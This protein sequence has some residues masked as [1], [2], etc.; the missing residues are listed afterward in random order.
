M[1]KRID[2]SI[3]VCTYNRASLL[4]RALQ[5][6]AVQQC[7]EGLEYEV[8]VVDDGSTD[9]TAEVVREAN[10]CTHRRV[11]YVREIGRGVSAARNRGVNAARGEWIAFTDDDQI[12]DRVWLWNLWFAQGKSGAPCVGG[13][14]TLELREQILRAL[15]NQIRLI[16]G[17][18][19]PAG[20]LHRC[21]RDA[22]LCTGN[23]LVRRDLILQLGGFDETLTQGGEDTDLLM[24]MRAAGHESWFTPH[25]IV[26]HIIPPYRLEAGYLVWSAIRGGDCF[27]VR[28]VREWGATR[29]C[30]AAGARLL[31]AVIVHLPA[32]WYTRLLRDDARSTA[33]RCRYARA[34]A[35]AK[36]VI[37]LALLPNGNPES[38]AGAAIEFRGERQMFDQSSGKEARCA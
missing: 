29:P 19:A 33:F 27:A 37:A 26:R 18:I 35:Y 34:M 22:L 5:S 38:P 20:E 6:L 24:R 15:P 25:A 9:N 16:L 1:N 14:R 8:I 12:A 13:A 11:V 4:E 21:T 30:M 7:P 17:E 28:D 36:R 3:V 23:L 10:R 31:Q 32:M 2:I